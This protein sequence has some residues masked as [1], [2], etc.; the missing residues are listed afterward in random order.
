MKLKIIILSFVLLMSGILLGQQLSLT[1]IPASSYDISHRDEWA[2]NVQNL[3]KE[4]ISVYFVGIATEQQ[5]GLVFKITSGVLLIP[6]G[7][8]QFNTSYYLGLEPYTIEY[9]DPVLRQNAIA[10]NGL[11]AGQYEMCVVAYESQTS[12]EIA[13]TCYSFAVD[14]CT[15]PE[16]ILPANA[17]TL[18]EDFPYFM[19]MPSVP[20]P[21][22][23]SSYTLKIFELQNNQTPWSAAQTNP[24]FYE[25]KGIQ[26]AY[27]QY[28]INS[29][30]FSPGKAYAWKVEVVSNGNIVCS[31]EVNMFYFIVNEETDIV[32]ENVADI[33]SPKA[34]VAYIPTA[35]DDGRG[36][37]SVDRGMICFSYEHDN[38]NG[39]VGMRIL[40]SNKIDIYNTVLEVQSGMNYFDFRA[41]D[42][43]AI[44]PGEVYQ[45]QVINALGVIKSVQFKLVNK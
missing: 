16:L 36:V 2:L 23:Q 38:S 43:K 18:T 29:R 39:E 44:K 28:G 6:P 3:G 1:I 30:N 8:T 20:P 7:A 32:P 19:W 24:S 35:V 40:N 10:L 25:M 42:L 9:E 15:P 26:S 17:D 4:A 37:S 14:D 21:S 5:R 34:G 11:P 41:S 31:S 22:G 13:S 45:I 12:V 33:N 27:F